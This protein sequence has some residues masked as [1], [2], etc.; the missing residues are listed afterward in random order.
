MFANDKTAA[1]PIWRLEFL[2]NKTEQN[3]V[4][5]S[6]LAPLITPWVSLLF[7]AETFV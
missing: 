7:C 2:A 1:E 5:Y 6:G 3:E 4:K